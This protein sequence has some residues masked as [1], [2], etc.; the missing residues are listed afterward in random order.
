MTFPVIMEPYDSARVQGA[1]ETHEIFLPATDYQQR[2]DGD[3]C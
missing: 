3:Q 2:Q 1:F